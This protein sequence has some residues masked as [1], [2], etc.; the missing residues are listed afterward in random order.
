MNLAS[1]EFSTGPDLSNPVEL[2]RICLEMADGLEQQ[3]KAS[4]AGSAM[5]GAPYPEQFYRRCAEVFGLCA[6]YIKEHSAPPSV[7]PPV[8]V[9]SAEPVG[10]EKEKKK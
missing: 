8:V 10:T 2:T 3:A 7:D 4:R 1:A 6:T 9:K 5:S